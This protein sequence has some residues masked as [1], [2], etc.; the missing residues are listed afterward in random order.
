MTETALIRLLRKKLSPE[1]LVTL[2]EFLPDS[3][4]PPEWSGEQALALARALELRVSATRQRIEDRYLNLADLPE[5]RRVTFLQNSSGSTLAQLTRTLIRQ[6]FEHRFDDVRRSLRLGELALETAQVVREMGYPYPEAASDLAGE[7]YAYL[8]NALRLNSD[9]QGAEKAFQCA[10]QLIASGTGDR[11]LRASLYSL[12]ASLRSVTGQ[13]SEAAEL[14]DREIQL[15]RLLAEEVA[16]GNALVNRGI[17]ET[18]IG[19]LDRACRFFEDGVQRTNDPKMMLLALMAVCERHARNGEGLGAWRVLCAA[20]TVSTMI[21][22]GSIQLYL[23][24]TKGITYR[25]LGELDLAAIEL[26]QVRARF[27]QQ[28]ARLLTALVSLDL[29][30]VRAAQGRLAEVR[31]LAEE[32]Y[33]VFKAERL[34]R[35]AL[36]AFLVL[37]QAAQAETVSAA[38]ARRVADFLVRFQYDRSTKFQGGDEW[39]ERRV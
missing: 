13:S 6:S 2:R 22:C 12:W 35:R 25:A 26:E 15:R 16:L 3:G 1:D 36:S 17:I 4:E 37:Y 23:R 28:D 14:F 39:Q 31:E 20:E 19:D 34:E 30:S 33:A 29:A 10:E 32:A 7:A 27:T 11:A 18:W 38:L 8:G 21:E 9:V 24:W 5:G